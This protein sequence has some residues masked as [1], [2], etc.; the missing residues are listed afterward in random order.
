M[1]S[2]VKCYFISTESTSITYI[3]DINKQKRRDFKKIIQILVQ[4]YAIKHIQCQ[5]RIFI[6][7]V[8]SLEIKQKLLT[9][10]HRILKYKHAKMSKNKFIPYINQTKFK[11]N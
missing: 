5:F 11:I 7:A 9:K 1:L 4:S 10:Y 6:Y 8:I 3:C 2:Q